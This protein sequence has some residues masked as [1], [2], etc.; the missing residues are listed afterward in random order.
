MFCSPCTTG[1]GKKQYKEKVRSCADKN[2]ADSRNQRNRETLSLSSH[3]LGQVPGKPELMESG[4]N[5]ADD[6]AQDI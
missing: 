1:R 5:D 2:L 6:Q 3:N 4:L